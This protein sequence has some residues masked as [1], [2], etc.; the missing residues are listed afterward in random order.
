MLLLLLLQITQTNCDQFILINF[1]IL[2][3]FP[4]IES[5]FFRM[6]LIMTPRQAY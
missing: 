6:K 5:V 4:V 2:T 3:T 1:N